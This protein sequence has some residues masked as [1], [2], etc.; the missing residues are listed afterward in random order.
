MRH[1][2]IALLIGGAA[3]VLAGCVETNADHM[4]KAPAEK[5]STVQFE[6]SNVQVSW[7]PS[8]K[9]SAT[10][11]HSDKLSIWS[12]DAERLIEEAT[13]C[14]VRSGVLSYPERETDGT[15]SVSMPINCG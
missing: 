6:G 2:T 8:A 10:L 5:I 12:G 15:K 11:T 7:D 4:M 13:G 14:Q 3:V 1:I 9:T